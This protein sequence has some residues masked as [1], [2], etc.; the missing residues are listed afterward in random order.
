[1]ITGAAVGAECDCG[2]GMSWVGEGGDG[3]VGVRIT[4]LQI[5]DPNEGSAQDERAGA[6]WAD[7]YAFR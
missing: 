7:D 3:G 6:A 5:I 1:M 4:H 2:L